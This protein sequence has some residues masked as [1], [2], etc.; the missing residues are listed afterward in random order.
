[1]A[2]LDTCTQSYK[3][4]R[5]KGDVEQNDRSIMRFWLIFVL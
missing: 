3:V 5:V 4:Q 1:M 2:P